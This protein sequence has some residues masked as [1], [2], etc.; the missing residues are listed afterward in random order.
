MQRVVV[1]ESG[2]IRPDKKAKGRVVMVADGKKIWLQVEDKHSSPESPKVLNQQAICDFKD[3]FATRRIQAPDTIAKQNKFVLEIFTQIGA[4]LSVGPMSDLDADTLEKSINK[5]QVIEFRQIPS[6]T[7]TSY[8]GFAT[9]NED[10]SGFVRFFVTNKSLQIGFGEDAD[11]ATSGFPKMLD[12]RVTHLVPLETSMTFDIDAF[13]GGISSE[14]KKQ[15]RAGATVALF[16]VVG[17]ATILIPQKKVTVTTDSRLFE[18]RMA[19]KGW[20]LLLVFP[21][22]YLEHVQI[23]RGSIQKT[24]INNTPQSELDKAEKAS[25]VIEPAGTKGVSV[26]EELGNAAKLL[27]AGL[28]SREEFDAIKTKLM[29]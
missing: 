28:I 21:A 26:V 15:V 6:S 18:M 19:G 2:F 25:Q 8:S 10:P 27:D 20:Q 9:K 3:I 22:E 5:E 16:P 17:L 7:E 24:I 23:L 4:G 14:T 1:I 11:I 13:S 29:S 12:G